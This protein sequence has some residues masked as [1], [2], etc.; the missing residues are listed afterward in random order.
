M[1]IPGSPVAAPPASDVSL[2][3]LP[4]TPKIS[5]GAPFPPLP[6]PLAPTPDPI[7]FAD[8]DVVLRSSD[9][10]DFKV[11]SI[12]LREASPFFRDMFRLPKASGASAAYAPILMT[13]TTNVLNDLL[14]WIYP[15]NTAPTVDKISHA[16]DLLR[17]VEKLQIESHVVK[18]A[19]NAYIVAQSHPLRS[20]ALA[21]RFG[22]KEARKDAVRKY[23]AT[24]EDFMDD[25]PTE[26]EFADAKAYMQL[27]RVKRT[28]IGLATDIIRSDV[29]VCPDCRRVQAPWRTQ[30]LQR[31]SS[32][33]PFEGAL[34]SDL[35]VEMF[36]S[37]HGYDCCRGKVKTQ[38]T[39]TMSHLR[40]RLAELLT[41]AGEAEYS[42]DVLSISAEP[43]AG[44]PGTPGSARSDVSF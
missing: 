40:H 35:M 3:S 4:P 15:T 42:G 9:G 22:Y 32:T 11:H 33:N 8:G 19:L 38:C 28:A 36:V 31:V 41:S 30:Y 37:H 34:T 7:Q 39:P 44:T 23:L 25:I 16:L 10:Q 14:R 13:E 21:T 17:A 27:V 12:V 18:G 24:D 1:S 20:W 5:R 29:W 26:M 6:E 43:L 2:V